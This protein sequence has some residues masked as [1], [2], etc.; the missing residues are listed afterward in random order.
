[1]LGLF[2]SEE[3]QKRSS[4]HLPHFYLFSAPPD[5]MEHVT[6]KGTE[7]TQGYSQWNHGKWMEKWD[8]V[9]AAMPM[10]LNGNLYDMTAL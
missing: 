1:M 5:A 4:F 3:F 10:S 2:A 7:L 6:V 9:T 8:S